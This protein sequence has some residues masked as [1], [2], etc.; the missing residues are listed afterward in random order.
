[1]PTIKHYSND[2]TLTQL[3]DMKASCKFWFLNACVEFATFKLEHPETT[4]NA[5]MQKIEREYAINMSILD[6]LIQYCKCFHNVKLDAALCHPI[7]VSRETPFKYMTSK[8]DQLHNPREWK[9]SV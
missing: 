1:M 2:E 9:I 4:M 8:F 7:G 3:E 5:I 6:E